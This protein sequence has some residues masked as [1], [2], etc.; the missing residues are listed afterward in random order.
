MIKVVDN[1]DHYISEKTC[2]LII[3][4]DSAVHNLNNYREKHYC[5]QQRIIFA[6]QQHIQ[7]NVSKG[8][9]PILMK[10]WGNIGFIKIFN[11][12]FLLSA[13]VHVM[14]VETVLRCFL[15]LST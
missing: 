5:F 3:K 10:L 9:T 12:Y 1:I 8:K 2:S 6:T 4:F 14:G 11:T 7:W 13:I 15:L